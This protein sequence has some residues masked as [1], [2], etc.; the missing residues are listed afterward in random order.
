MRQSRAVEHVV[1]MERG[2]R[3]YDPVAPGTFCDSISADLDRLVTRRPHRE[4]PSA[5]TRPRE[6]PKKARSWTRWF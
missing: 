4:P 2:D 3:G 1:A 6:A 5:A